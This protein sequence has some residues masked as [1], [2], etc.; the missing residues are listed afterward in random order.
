MDAGFAVLLISLIFEL[1]G[2]NL[3]CQLLS[4]LLLVAFLSVVLKSHFNLQVEVAIP[5]LNPEMVCKEFAVYMNYEMSKHY[6]YLF[7]PVNTAIIFR[8]CFD[9]IYVQCYSC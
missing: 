4:L 5:E 3:Q 7:M 8:S 1:M 2:N 6:Y 9:L